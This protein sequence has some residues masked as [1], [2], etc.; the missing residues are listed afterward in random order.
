MSEEAVVR[1]VASLAAIMHPVKVGRDGA[2]IT[3]DVPLSE[4]LEVMKLELLTDMA[5][6][7]T[8]RPVVQT[9]ENQG[10]GT[11]KRPA[12]TTR[13]ARRPTDLAGS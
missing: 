11:T 13:A 8:I 9:K 10:D 5:F 12:I 4:R 2:R 3:I 1:F 7:V 6:E